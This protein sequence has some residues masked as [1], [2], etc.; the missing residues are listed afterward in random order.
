[1]FH[2][3]TPPEQTLNRDARTEGAS[4]KD[5]GDLPEWDL[6]D[7]YAAED[8]KELK[9]DMAFLEKELKPYINENYNAAAFDV[10]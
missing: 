8:A 10:A 3:I 9:R 2:Q 7:L 1:M 4:G 6:T 5:F